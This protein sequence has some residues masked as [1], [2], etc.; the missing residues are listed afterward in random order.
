MTKMVEVPHIDGTTREVEEGEPILLQYDNGEVA[1]R[2][3][4]EG[5]YRL[6]IGVGSDAFVVLWDESNAKVKAVLV[7]GDEPPIAVKVPTKI[8][9]VIGSDDG[10]RAVYSGNGSWYSTTGMRWGQD[11]IAELCEHPSVTRVIFEGVDESSAKVEE[12][13]VKKEPVEKSAKV[14]TKPGAII[15]DTDGEPAWVLSRDDCDGKPWVGLY[16][17]G[18]RVSDDTIGSHLRVGY[19]VVFEGAGY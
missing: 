7:E 8:G 10:W 13:S 18:V 14:P 15:A 4:A 5:G 17:P 12:M 2:F 19:K 1:V 9:A 6:V 16:N 11:E 3:A